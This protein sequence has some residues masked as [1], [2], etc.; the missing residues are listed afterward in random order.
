MLAEDLVRPWVLP[1]V[2][3]RM[4]AGRGELLAELRPA[5]P[6]FVRFGGLDFDA[7]PTA[8]E[9]LDRFVRRTQRVFAGHGG[10]VLQLTIG[11]KGAYL[12]AVFGAPVAHEDDAARA[13]AAALD[14]LADE[15]A[16]DRHRP[17]RRDRRPDGCAAA[18]TATGSGVRSA[19]WGTP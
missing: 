2:W 10:Y 17:Q 12:Y 13:C 15:R 6:V 1:P 9:R 3:D 4:V 7:D 11:D 14:L 16:A 18:P 8:P 19:A 5:V